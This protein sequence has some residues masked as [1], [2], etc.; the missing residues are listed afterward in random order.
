MRGVDKILTRNYI[1]RPVRKLLFSRSGG[2]CSRC[3]EKLYD[4]YD[5]GTFTFSGE[6]CHIKGLKPNSSRYDKN[7]PKSKLN[8]YENL[9]ILCSK[10]HTIVDQEPKKFSVRFLRKLKSSHEE[11][12]ENRIEDGTYSD[13]LS[14]YYALGLPGRIVL[15][16]NLT[17]SKSGI[18]NRRFAVPTLEDLK[19]NRI[20]K[21]LEVKELTKIL[22][23]SSTEIQYENAIVFGP[24]GSGKT[25]LALSFGYNLWKSDWDVFYTE[26]IDLIGF[27]Q[28]I[29][30][31]LIQWQNP[32]LLIIDDINSILRSTVDSVSK[33][34][35]T[36]QTIHIILQGIL[37]SIK[38]NQ[39]SCIRILLLSRSSDRLDYYE[40]LIPSDFIIGPID[41]Y[42]VI[43]ELYKTI[44]NEIGYSLDEIVGI[45]GSEIPIFLEAVTYLEKNEQ[46]DLENLSKG[47]INRRIVDLDPIVYSTGETC[48]L[49]VALF[50]RASCRVSTRFLI[51]YLSMSKPK[52][53]A[54]EET[55][56]F[57]INEGRFSTKLVNS[58]QLLSIE[59]A[60]IAKLFL[61]NYGKKKLLKAIKTI[62]HKLTPK[63]DFIDIENVVNFNYL[64]SSPPGLPS[65]LISITDFMRTAPDDSLILPD[66]IWTAI[67]QTSFDRIEYAGGLSNLG[68]FLDAAGNYV[69]AEA[70]FKIA[71]SID[72]EEVMALNNLGMMM[73]DLGRLDEA[74]RAY[75]LAI[76][77]NPEFL[78][79]WVH[80]GVTLYQMN[81][82]EEAR[83]FFQKA[84]PIGDKLLKAKH[85]PI[86][87]AWYNLG[88]VL[89][90]LGQKEEAK[91]SYRKA[92]EIRPKYREAKLNLAVLLEEEGELEESE[93]ILRDVLEDNPVD[94][95]A[96]NNL[97]VVHMKLKQFIGARDAWKKAVDYGY[98]AKQ[99]LFGIEKKLEELKDLE[100]K[101]RD[102][103]DKNH[104][105]GDAW[106]MLASILYT[107]EKRKEA[108]EA[109]E[110]AKRIFP[111]KLF[112]RKL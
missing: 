109:L 103:I 57:L 68:V 10:C 59:H 72:P 25:V 4:I 49:L 18:V 48:L 102:A 60:T 75:R 54:I 62:E 111:E 79:P 55:V 13:F 42:E 3:R 71:I 98:D 15:F 43:T 106:S 52:L 40:Q 63:A 84:I 39:N 73:N 35:S 31:N 50:S 65:F 97:A 100:I 90:E 77:R 56:K 51:D 17:S 110:Q 22:S 89:S 45:I 87:I 6:V 46:L 1:P 26:A 69:S 28:T 32:V 24:S 12:I 30:K 96:W 95:T 92:L 34:T 88:I 19:L 11:F 70:A 105:D 36:N 29:I 112:D 107:T 91:E 94:S 7:Y 101:C 41:G 27:D 82:L 76:K 67:K 83:D 23:P 53:I 20:V 16:E 44:P 14:S 21:R 93:K 66:M 64:K 2:F 9:L 61:S 86:S 38:G 108:T 5:T 80:L 37:D 8:Q 58:S 99:E 85:P 81:R 33:R 104:D 74:E 78:L 47:A